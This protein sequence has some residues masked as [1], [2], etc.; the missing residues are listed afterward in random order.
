MQN[1]N[2]NQNQN[3]EGQ[4]PDEQTAS[5]FED[6]ANFGDDDIMQ[7]H[8]AIRSAEADKI[9]F[10]GEK[11]P[12][13][14]LAAEYESGSP[15]LIEKIKVL[16][17]QYVA[18]RRTRGDGN[19]FFRSFMFSYLEHILETQDR[20]EVDQIKRKVEECRKTLQSLGYAD[21]TFEDF[22]ALFL[23]QLDCVLQGNESSISHDELLNRSRDQSISD[24]VVM[25]FRFVT[26]GEIRKRSEFFEPFILGLM[27]ATVE[28]FCKSSVEPMGEESD[29]VHITA[30]SDALGVP[31]RI[32]Y[33]DRSSCDT[34]GVSVNHHDFIPAADDLP[35][36]TSGDSVTKNPFITL[37]YRP[38]HYDILYAK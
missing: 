20:A 12:I 3:L 8:S 37:L 1:Q 17:E 14:A 26:S 10:L 18:I 30:L 4:L 28:Q 24:Y 9:P 29:H 23:E 32:V 19:C 38:G 2:H 22:F 35:N 6:W 25:F 33:L 34:G 31:I 13:S 36:S 7:Q 27:N 15:I 5:Q 16:A 11:E 21:F